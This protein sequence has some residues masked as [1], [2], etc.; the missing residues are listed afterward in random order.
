MHFNLLEKTFELLLSKGKLDNDWIKSQINRLD[1]FDGEIDTLLN[2]ISNIRTWT[3]ITNRTKWLDESD[4]W[5][6]KAKNIEDKLS[7]ELHRRLT[8]RFVDKRIVILNKTLKEHNNLEAVIRLDGT[9]FVEGEEVGKLNG[10]DFTPSLSQGEKAGPILTAA[11]KILPKEIERRLRELLKSDNA[12]FK[13]NNDASISWQ[14][15][16]VATL[17]NSENIYL[18]NINIIL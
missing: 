11:R 18:P 12:A 1:N 15:N 4:Y 16:K 7:D 17:L 10:F 8:Q 9:V 13:F 3:F 5:Q 2:R 6:N 14:S